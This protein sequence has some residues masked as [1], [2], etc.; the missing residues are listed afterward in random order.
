M[1]NQALAPVVEEVQ[2]FQ[3]TLRPIVITSASDY[4]E[5]GDIIKKVGNKVRELESKRLEMTR[6]L[7]LSKKLIMDEFKRLTDP[8]ERF[9]NETKAVMLDFHRKETARIAEEQRIAREKAEAEARAAAEA[10][11][12]ED[13]KKTKAAED[14]GL[15]SALFVEPEPEEVDLPLP[16]A[17]QTPIKT[18]RGAVST[19]TVK[20]NWQYEIIDAAAVPRQYCEPSRDHIRQSIIAGTR[21]IPGV[22]IYDAG[23]IQIR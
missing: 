3:A 6:P 2:N 14:M 19:T 7:D 18:Q 16:L 5:A 21:E 22:R 20:E 23:T 8:L 10:K 4:A 17:P 12:I 15:P 9:V 1:E 11:R 13:E